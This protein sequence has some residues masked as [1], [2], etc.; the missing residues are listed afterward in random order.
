MN[1]SGVTNMK[2]NRY[3][4]KPQSTPRLRRRSRSTAQF[5]ATAFIGKIARKSGFSAAC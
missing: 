4:A 2:P 5:L 3:E 1:P